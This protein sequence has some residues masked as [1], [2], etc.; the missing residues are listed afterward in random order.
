M[1]DG[2][3]LMADS[4]LRKSYCL[5]VVIAVVAFDF[6]VIWLTS[7]E[8]ARYAYVALQTP[9]VTVLSRPAWSYE[10]VTR[11]EGWEPSSTGAGACPGARFQ[12]S[13]GGVGVIRA[14]VVGIAFVVEPT[15]ICIVVPAGDSCGGARSEIGPVG[16]CGHPALSVVT[17][18]D[19]VD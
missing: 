7:G 4:R 1:A 12:A 11:V 6:R 13:G 10:Y 2:K 19:R 8:F 15:A 17:V 16:H 3:L 14:G 18:T 9:L 5:V